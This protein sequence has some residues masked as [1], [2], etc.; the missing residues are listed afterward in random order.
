MAKN[1]FD[2]SV[3]LRVTHPTKSAAELS[4]LVAMT[5]RHSWSVGDAR[6]TPKGTALGGVRDESYC[7]FDAGRG[8]D[9][10]IAALLRTA[11]ASLSKR[12]EAL[13]DIRSTGGEIMLLVYWH[14]DGD[15]GETFDTDLLGSMS[16]LGIEL[17]LNVLALGGICAEI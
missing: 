6:V 9:G 10:R 12:A 4:Q 2:F 5:P 17:G 3:S 13:H 11:V 7:S 15:E 1:P 8:E 16:E 14:A